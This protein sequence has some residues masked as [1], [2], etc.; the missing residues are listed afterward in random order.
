MCSVQLPESS[1]YGL[2]FCLD[3]VLTHIWRAALTTGGKRN[4]L[5]SA[6]E[7]AA[8]EVEEETHWQL[9]SSL[10]RRLLKKSAGMWCV[11]QHFVCMAVNGAG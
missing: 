8:R 6:Q 5:E 7:T 1:D 9:P 10:V 2:T 4:G 3:Q 11:A